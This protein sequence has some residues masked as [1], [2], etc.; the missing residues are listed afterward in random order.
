VLP[1]IKKAVLGFG[2][3][4]VKFF[5]DH[6]GVLTEATFTDEFGQANS[7]LVPEYV[8]LNSLAECFKFIDESGEGQITLAQLYT[9]IT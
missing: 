8:S 3:N 2:L 1:I 9:K 7:Q 4:L 5:E 6:R